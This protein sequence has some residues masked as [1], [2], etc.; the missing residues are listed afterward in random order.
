MGLGFN[1]L[2]IRVDV[3]GWHVVTEPHAVTETS[4]G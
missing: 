1:Q 2:I 4:G 3:R